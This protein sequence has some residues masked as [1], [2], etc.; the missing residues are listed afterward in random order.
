VALGLSALLTLCLYALVLPQ[1]VGEILRPTMGGE[2][3]EWT[4]LRWMLSETARVLDTGVP[5]GPFAVLVAVGVLVIG[6]V[7]YFRGSRRVALVMAS[8]VVVTA[9]VML[10]LRHNLWPR[11]FF[12]AAAFFVLFGLRGGFVLARW[13]MPVRGEA[14][15]RA[16]AVALAALSAFMLPR[17]WQPKQQF[18]AAARYVE[19][20]RVAGDA[21]AAV[22]LAAAAYRHRGPPDGWRLVPSLDSL[23]ALER[24]SR[25]TWVLYTFPVHLR[26]REASLAARI[27]Q[28]PYHAVRRF[29]ATV[30]G[31]EIRIVRND[32]P[33]S[34]D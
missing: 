27:E 9:V 19:A 20:N 18:D 23:V 2:Q 14:V 11:F 10:S 8:P 17:A 34:H 5:G 25:R 24:S 3:V 29:S 33:P 4:S 13:L 6:A 30:G 15:A 12:F 22:G 7:S 26:A 32:T 31:G 1:L 28:P 21:V 16:G